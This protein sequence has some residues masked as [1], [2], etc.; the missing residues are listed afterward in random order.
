MQ[1]GNMCA[2]STNS[3]SVSVI[4]SIVPIADAGIDHN[5]DSGVTM[6]LDGCGGSE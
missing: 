5:V 2:A 4:W 1:N 3:N 6:Q